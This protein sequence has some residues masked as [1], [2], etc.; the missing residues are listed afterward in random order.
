MS[1]LQEIFA[2]GNA[3]DLRELALAAG[4]R[5][6][7]VKPFSFTA[8]FPNPG[9]FIAGEIEVDTASIP[10]MQHLDSKARETIVTAITRDM[11]LPLKERISDDHVVIPFHGLMMTARP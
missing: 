5:Q 4:F 1:A 9:A 10:S 8:R 6:V 3:D 7:D 11:Q 2:L